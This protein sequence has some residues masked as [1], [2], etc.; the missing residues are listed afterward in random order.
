MMKTNLLTLSYQLRSDFFRDKSESHTEAI[1]AE[2]AKTKGI[3]YPVEASH[4][5][6][7]VPVPCSLQANQTLRIPT[8]NSCTLCSNSTLI[9]VASYLEVLSVFLYSL[10]NVVH[11]LHGI[12]IGLLNNYLKVLL[13]LLLGFAV[14]D[15]QLSALVL[16]KAVFQEDSNATLVFFH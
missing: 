2:L 1:A 8:D 9:F 4:L 12:N 5:D 15:V 3:L 10:S 13:L 14:N 7:V 16:G 6:F 11:C